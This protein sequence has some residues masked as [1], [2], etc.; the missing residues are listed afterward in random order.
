MGA[1]LILGYAPAPRKLSQEILDRL[2]LEVQ[3]LSE[4]DLEDA[5]ETTY[6][7]SVENIYEGYGEARAAVRE[8]VTSL[9]EDGDR[10]RHHMPNGIMGGSPCWVAGGTSWGDSFEALDEMNLVYGAGLLDR[11]GRA[12]WISSQSEV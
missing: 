10:Y 1:D 3:S 6:G 4:D 5:V 11:F 9:F 7:S 12:C 2:L 8:A